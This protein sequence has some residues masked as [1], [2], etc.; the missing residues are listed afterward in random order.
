MLASNL[1]SIAKQSLPIAA[2]LGLISFINSLPV[3][4]PIE[5]KLVNLPQATSLHLANPNELNQN[6]E[7]G[8]LD[9]GAMSAFYYL[10]SNDLTLLPNISISSLGP[11]GS[12]LLFSK[13]E[14]NQLASKNISVTTASATSVNLLKILFL[15]EYG[16]VPNIISEKD[17][18]INKENIS[19]V[20]LI[21]DAALAK[22]AELSKY[23]RIDLSS[24]WVNKF[25][26]P[27]VFGVWAAKNKFAQN[28]QSLV[29]E[30]AA[31]LMEAKT[32]GLGKYFEDMIAY[33]QKT[34]N[35]SKERLKNYYC[36]ELNFELTDK[37][38]QAL[39]LYGQ[40]AHKHNLI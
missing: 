20:L 25:N 21:G 7:K 19:A 2:R 6:F 18:D 9:I 26:L 23:V 39:N 1:T 31:N 36:E 4:W 40:L 16:F 5:N 34:S 29:N 14:L 22:D 35:F 28:N 33:A 38:M 24:W 8:L 10:Q 17:P 15:E 37:H 11:V 12:V 13:L 27:I 3:V 32:L 30:I